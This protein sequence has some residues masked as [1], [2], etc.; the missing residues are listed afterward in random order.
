MVYAGPLHGR[1]TAS[2]RGVAYMKYRIYQ[3]AMAIALATVTLVH[4]FGAKWG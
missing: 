4:T 1:T 2:T 3:Y